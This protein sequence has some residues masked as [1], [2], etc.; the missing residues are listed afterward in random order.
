MIRTA[1]GTGGAEAWYEG[2]GEL[3]AE[4]TRELPPPGLKGVLALERCAL[5]VLVEQSGHVTIPT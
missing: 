4:R 3:L 1:E 5:E 2:I